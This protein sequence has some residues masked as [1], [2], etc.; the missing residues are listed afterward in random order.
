MKNSHL[1]IER[2]YRID[3]LPRGLQSYPHKEIAQCYLAV[4]VLYQLASFIAL[5]VTIPA[6]VH[7]W[8]EG[9]LAPGQPDALKQ[10]A[11]RLLDP[12]TQTLQGRAERP[13]GKLQTS[14]TGRSL[15]DSRKPA[16]AFDFHDPGA[17]DESKYPK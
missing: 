13:A 10:L 6:A 14:T 5:P 4:R 12:L 7:Q 16:P 17:G 2:K 11:E 9:Q 15:H 3:T 1:E 8:L